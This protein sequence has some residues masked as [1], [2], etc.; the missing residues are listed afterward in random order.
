MLEDIIKN[1]PALSGMDP[2]KLKF[3][4]EFSRKKMPENMQEAMP[5]LLANLNNAKQQNINFEKP[6]V[7]LITELLCQNLP[8]DEQARVK[9]M[10]AL[11]NQMNKNRGN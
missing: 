3:I 5:F 7:E 4:T 11:I 10:L 8:A 9:K 6:E 1:H 2:Q